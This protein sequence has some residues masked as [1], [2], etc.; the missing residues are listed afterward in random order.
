MADEDKTAT[1]A[2]EGEQPEEEKRSKGPIKLIGG[3]VGVLGLG[4]AAAIMAIPTRD[5]TP[6]FLGVFHH[7]IFEEKFSAN[8]RDNNQ[9]RFL[10]LM[11]DCEYSA[12]SPDYLAAR[13]ED[14]LYEPRLRDAVGRVVSDK[15]LVDT[16]EGPAR[17]AFLAELR[18]VLDPILF[19][20]HIGDT[21]LPLELD[22]ESGI[23]LGISYY[24][25]TLRGRFFEHVIKIDAVSGTLQIDEGPTV[26]FTG[27]EEDLLVTTE[28]GD[29]VYVD[30]TGVD[31]DYEGEVQIGVKG[32]LRRLYA[33]DLI[34]Q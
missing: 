30:V 10:Q 12:Y 22:E 29:I 26:S 28:V 31:S 19:P 7:S 4:V 11:L 17:E 20:I 21:R 8:L 15:F 16:Y 6:R 34:A 18:D 32:R 2:P 3:I 1:E 14:P 23:R 5:T 25:S 27:G 9:T 13:V 24:K 33:K